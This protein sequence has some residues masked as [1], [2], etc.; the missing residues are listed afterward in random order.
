V[1]HYVKWQKVLEE[2]ASIQLVTPEKTVASRRASTTQIPGHLFE[3]ERE[4]HS[5]FDN[6]GIIE[7]PMVT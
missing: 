6:Y 5:H 2:Y 7:Q 1:A 4:L 3:L